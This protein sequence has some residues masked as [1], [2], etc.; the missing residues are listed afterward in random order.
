MKKNVLPLLLLIPCC[1]SCSGKPSFPFSKD[2][3]KAFI[4]RNGNV[5][6]LNDR[7]LGYELG[8]NTSYQEIARRLNN[9]ESALILMHSTTC[10]HCRTFEPRFADYVIDSDIAI[11]TYDER[12]YHTFVNGIV[13][14][15]PGLSGL[16]NDFSGTPEMFVLE[17]PS[18]Y[19]KLSFLSHSETSSS[20]ESYM[21]GKI[22][23]VNSYRFTSYDGFEGFHRDRKPLVLFD[24][25]DSSFYK[26]EVLSLTRQKGAY[27]AII[28]TKSLTQSD[29]SRFKS[30]LSLDDVEDMVVSKDGVAYDY[31]K[32]PSLSRELV[33][34]HYK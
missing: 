2:A 7:S 25:D 19:K 18:S 27:L 17:S 23:H 30:Y 12:S 14:T 24:D 6:G 20:F 22:N 4:E 33:I 31:E 29:I 15:L 5:Y 8:R 21:K 34:E 26:D 1:L 10:G 32:E 16:R 28:D 9:G 13:N 11:E 3:G